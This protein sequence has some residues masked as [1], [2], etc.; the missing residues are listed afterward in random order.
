MPAAPLKES[1]VVLSRP[2]TSVSPAH[3]Q[4]SGKRPSRQLSRRD[5]Q[6]EARQNAQVYID[7]WQTG[8]FADVPDKRLMGMGP[9]VMGEA[10]DD[11]LRRL[12]MEGS[13]VSQE[14]A[15]ARREATLIHERHSA[16]WEKL[17][18]TREDLAVSQAECVRLTQELILARACLED[19]D[20]MWTHNKNQRH[21]RSLPLRQ[22]MLQVPE[23]GMTPDL[24][25][26]DAQGDAAPN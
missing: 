14:L 26:V 23:R 7:R 5:T 3:G 11:L 15:E 20:A 21:S 25:R 22:D 9:R 17:H 12:R 8:P 18:K 13:R 1:D 19:L 4:L 24:Y 16:T 2:Q 10:H 6:R